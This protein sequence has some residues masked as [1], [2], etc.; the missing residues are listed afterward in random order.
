MKW[1]NWLTAGAIY[2]VIAVSL[3]AG[4]AA[5]YGRELEAKRKP[6]RAWWVRR[7]LIFPVLAIIASAATDLFK[8]SPTIAAFSTAMLSIGGYDVICLIERRWL[9][10]VEAMALKAAE[11]LSTGDNRP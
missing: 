11:A 9:R 7:L 5:A 10:R 6:D 1:W 8:L 3:L 4:L 2:I